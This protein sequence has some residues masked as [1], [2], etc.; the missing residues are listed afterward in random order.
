[1]S[2]P[3]QEGTQAIRRAAAV[4]RRVAADADNG[5]NLREVCEATDL[6]RSTAHR[7]MKCLMEEQLLD[8]NENT[9]R[10]TVGNLVFELGL[11]TTSRQTEV[12]KW[13]ALIDELARRCGATSYLLARSGYESVCLYKAEGSSVLR[14]I[15]VEVG[16]RRPL[17]VGAAATALLADTSEAETERILA[18]IAPHL[19]AHSRLDTA[20]IRHNIAEG[21]KTGFTESRDF[22][23]DNVY[24][25][26]MVL[27]TGQHPAMLAMSIATHTSLATPQNIAAWKRHFDDLRQQASAG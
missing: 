25:L 11:A 17:G 4:L 19:A 23:A 7:I 24:G 16:Q 8:Y 9:R 21:R 3:K 15:P 6:S 5:T 26:G 13:R 10:Y 20:Q 18:A 27:P 22:V 14:A 2:E 1:M 12:M